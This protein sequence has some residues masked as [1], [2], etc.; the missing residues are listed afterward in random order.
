MRGNVTRAGPFADSCLGR[1]CCRRACAAGLAGCQRGSLHRGGIF[2][3]HCS[4]APLTRCAERRA[5]RVTSSPRGM[6]NC[7]YSA[8]LRRR[9]QLHVGVPQCGRRGWRHPKASDCVSQTAQRAAP[10][11][12]RCATSWTLTPWAPRNAQFTQD[13]H[14]VLV[15]RACC[16]GCGGQCGAYQASHTLT[17]RARRRCAGAWRPAAG[18]RIPAS[19]RTLVRVQ[20]PGPQFMFYSGGLRGYPC[21][22]GSVCTARLALQADRGSFGDG[23]AC[24]ACGPRKG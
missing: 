19:A 24:G 16:C 14:P 10:W 11:W 15:L 1:A 20:G 18:A 3:T 21:Q 6:E 13:G 2:P 12:R 22:L 8:G 4:A 5:R 17:A 9:R 7:A 23:G